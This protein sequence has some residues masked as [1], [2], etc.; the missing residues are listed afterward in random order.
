M[1]PAVRVSTTSD[2]QKPND[3]DLRLK[4]NITRLFSGVDENTAHVLHRIF[5][6]WATIN[7]QRSQLISMMQ[8][9]KDQEFKSCAIA[10]VSAEMVSFSF[11]RDVLL[12]SSLKRN[13]QDAVAMETDEPCSTGLTL[14]PTHRAAVDLPSTMF[15]GKSKNA[16]T[17]AVV[18]RENAGQSSLI[19]NLLLWYGQ[20]MSGTV[21]KV[22]VDVVQYEL[23]EDLFL[24]ELPP[25]GQAGYSIK[26][27]CDAYQ[28]R[29][30]DV[31]VL[32]VGNRFRENDQEIIKTASK[33]PHPLPLIILSQA[34]PANRSMQNW[35]GYKT[36][37]GVDGEINAYLNR[38][39]YSNA[40][41]FVLTVGTDFSNRNSWENDEHMFLDKIGMCYEHFRKGKTQ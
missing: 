29:G 32:T 10:I 28:I 31:V 14:S 35:H 19:R 16:F 2:G 39:I 41:A 36:S 34:A 1:D 25:I 15:K 17:I 3:L 20:A 5:E 18:G 22:S 24:M 33:S 40:S 37:A 21:Q 13:H 6:K 11:S 9:G 27:F 38:H 26:N 30:Y 12:Q 7:D 4:E 8:R 23:T